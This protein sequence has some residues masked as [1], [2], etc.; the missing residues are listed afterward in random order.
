MRRF[1]VT[2][3]A[4]V[5]GLSVSFSM[6]LS[7][8]AQETAVAPEGAVAQTADCPE[9]LSEADCAALI[10]VPAPDT[11]VA[12]DAAPDV[13]PVA[14]P[15]PDPAPET[16]AETGVETPPAVPE[17]P[18]ETLPA[19]DVQP[20]TEAPPEIVQDPAPDPLPQ[21]AAETQQ[22]PVTPD[23][24]AEDAGTPDAAVEAQ[25]APD[26]LAEP[27]EPA[28]ADP[29]TSAPATA[30]VPASPAV[31]PT[32][33]PSDPA[34]SDTG[35][36]AAAQAAAQGG[37]TQALA[38][39]TGAQTTE[40]VEETTQTV[41]AADV[42]A[43]DQDFAAA[44]ESAASGSDGGLSPVERA[45]FAIA[46]GVVVG[47]LLSGNREIVST[48]P[49]RVVVQDPYG[50]LQVLRDDDAILRQSGSQV[51]T[52]SYADGSTQTAI[53]QPDGSRIVTIRD[54]ELRVLKRTVID[55]GGVETV[56]FD[57]TRVTAPVDLAALPQ[58]S[59]RVLPTIDTTDSAALRAALLQQ[60]AISRSFSLAQIRQID[61]VRYLAPAIDIESVTFE[62]GS[63]AIQ[64]S[65]AEE[66]F[67]LGQLMR[68][69]IAENPAE[70][71]LI[72]GHTDAVGSAASNLT[73]SDRRAESVSLALSE[74]FDVPPA[75][76]ILQGYG[77]TDLRIETQDAA[78]ENRRVVVRRIT[79]L[80]LSAQA[81]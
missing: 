30:E 23:A 78:R 29:Q 4:L 28:T 3:T 47:S 33:R 74:Y 64:P 77:E 41:V 17:Q 18:A 19:P 51:T 20:E 31:L 60:G 5:A 63:A 12:P 10:L 70:V 9:G 59:T 62:T 42:R 65:E 36:T 1:L 43:S 11:V 81:N 2:T 39:E 8:L 55:P 14:E 44:P 48:S 38:A 46:T 54:A 40:P 68:D 76:M 37:A 6:P 75:H 49:D 72:E 73:L 80:L 32:E 13:V 24:P 53:L 56:L 25:T 27:A 67:A 52:R 57:D 69:L 26:P 66:L 21:A 61:Q 15:E 45:I 58:V 71:F 22:D 7:V 50:N 35:L 79:P 34:Q 16:Q